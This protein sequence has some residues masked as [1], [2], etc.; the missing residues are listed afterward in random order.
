M[1]LGEWIPVVSAVVGGGAVAAIAAVL[2]YRL[3]KRKAVVEIEKLNLEIAKL[4]SEVDY[5]LSNLE[6]QILFDSR[7][8]LDGFDFDAKGV[9]IDRGQPVGE[10]RHKVLD[11]KVLNIERTNKEGRYEVVLKQL[12]YQ[13]AK[14][15]FVPANLA[16]AGQRK[17]KVR[18]LVKATGGRH[19][20]KTVLKTTG[21]G[22]VW[23]ASKNDYVEHQDQWEEV[24]CFFLVDPS[25]EFFIRFDDGEI[26]TVP[27]SVQIKDIVVSEK[28]S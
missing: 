25:A 20:I 16:I 27:S 8:A 4:K 14:R 23:L 13:N 7:Q 12:L 26:S 11:G 17:I 19:R 5:K 22:G 1:T 6:E 28:A 2:T 9:A 21:E 10:G 18:F 24:E 15:P 3:N